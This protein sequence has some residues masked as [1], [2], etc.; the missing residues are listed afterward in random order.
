[1]AQDLT[2]PA[3]DTRL[4]AVGGLVL[5]DLLPSAARPENGLVNSFG[6]A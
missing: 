1:M 6:A 2:I 4:H 5:I 3:A